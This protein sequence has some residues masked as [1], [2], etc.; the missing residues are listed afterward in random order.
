MPRKNKAED[1][2]KKTANGLGSIDLL[3]SGL[4]RWRVSVRVAGGKLVRF[5]GTEKTETGI[6]PVGRTYS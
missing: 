5:S 4:W 1:S 3:P 2:G 6:D